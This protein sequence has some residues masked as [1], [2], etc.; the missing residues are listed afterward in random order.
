[1]NLTELQRQA[2]KLWERD[3]NDDYPDKEV[4]VEYFLR[5][6]E[7]ELDEYERKHTK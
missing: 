6:K 4:M 7:E 1:V 2:I 3:F 5:Q